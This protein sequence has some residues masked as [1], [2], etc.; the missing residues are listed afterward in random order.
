MKKYISV[1]FL[2]LAVA[3]ASGCSEEDHFIREGSDGS[4]PA[5]VSELQ[6]ESLPGGAKISYKVPA[7]KDLLFVKAKYRVNS[8]TERETKT[9]AFTN[10]IVV[11]GFGDMEEKTISI[12]TVD[13]GGVESSPVEV[14]VTP[15][16]PPVTSVFKTLELREDFAGVNMT[17]QN[18]HLANLAFIILAKNDDGVL[19]E[20]EAVYS[21]VEEG[22]FTLRGLDT[23][24]NV[25]GAYVR[26]RWENRSD[27]ILAELKPLF[28]EEIDRTKWSQ[29]SGAGEVDLANWGGSFRAMVDY[30][31]GISNYGHTKGNESLPLYFSWDMKAKAKLS[32]IKIWQ[33]PGG[34]QFQHQNPRVYE[35]WGSNDPSTD[36]SFSGWTKLITCES[37][38]PSGLPYGKVSQEDNALVNR[39]EE[40]KFPAAASAYRY[41]RFVMLANWT[42]GGKDLH[43]SEMGC[44]GRVE[45]SF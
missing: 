1:L 45:E 28:E 7:D 41:L 24:K 30:R 23:L 15:M 5:S 18:E 42:P 26:D 22:D 2:A 27:T 40:F 44:W 35:I 16:E 43:I 36:G 11:D 3:L 33:R 29:L 20:R 14:K 4:A 17:W 34:Y 39:G 13:R 12:T 19:E 38:K 21:S 6:V 9:S 10:F 37:I 25:F 31:T 8:Q 32:R